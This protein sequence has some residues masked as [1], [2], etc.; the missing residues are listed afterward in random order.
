MRQ[1]ERLS[2][3]EREAEEALSALRPTRPA[4]DGSRLMF[5]AARRASRK[6]VWAWRG[7]AAAL[8]G[9]LVLALLLRPSPQLI[10]KPVYVDR[11]ATDAARPTQP[12][13]AAAPWQ[14]PEMAVRTGNDYVAMR[15]RVLAY[16]VGSLPRPQAPPGAVMPTLSDAPAD[17]PAP[18]PNA[19]LQLLD[20]LQF[21]GR[22]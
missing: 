18:P 1:E 21:G 9:G 10:E 22:S 11:S 20:T 19:L 6:Q 13:L 5:E 3:M 4:F 12:P 17:R 2:D 15:D 14:Q 8:A 7:I 16:G